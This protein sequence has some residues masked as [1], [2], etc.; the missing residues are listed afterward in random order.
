[1]KRKYITVLAIFLII[2]SV[3]VFFPSDK[4]SERVIVTRVIDGDTV[5]VE[6]GERVRLSGIDTQE[7]GEKCY[8][9]AKKR[10][11]E[12]ILKKKVKLVSDSR[13]KYDRKLGYIFYNNNLINEKLVSEGFAVAYFYEDSQYRDRIKE[14]EMNAIKTEAGCEW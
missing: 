11:E 8:Q 9:P 6:G 1:M 12:L 10:L 5:V 3:Y 2:V 13:D 4:G 7:R 14:A